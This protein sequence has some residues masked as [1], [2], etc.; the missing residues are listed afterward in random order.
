VVE[1]RPVKSFV[2]GSIPSLGAKIS[3]LWKL[4]LAGGGLETPVI[5]KWIGVSVIPF[6]P[7]L[8]RR[9][10]FPNG[11]VTSVATVDDCIQYKSNGC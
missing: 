10:G 4:C 9:C 6:P 1:Q 8:N 11:S 2:G 7:F 5:L 3:F